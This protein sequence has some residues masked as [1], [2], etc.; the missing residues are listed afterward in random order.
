LRNRRLTVAAKMKIL[1][2]MALNF[3]S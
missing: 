1:T 3:F 2:H